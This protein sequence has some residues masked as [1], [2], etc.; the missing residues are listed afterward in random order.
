MTAEIFIIGADGATGGMLENVLE[1]V[2]YK[3]QAFS[4]FPEAMESL[5]PSGTHLVFIDTAS[6]GLDLK[7]EIEAIQRV[8]PNI[9]IILIADYQDPLIEDDARKHH[10]GT[11][12]YRPFS[13]PEVILKVFGALEGAS[14][15]GADGLPVHPEPSDEHLHKQKHNLNQKQ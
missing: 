3:V 9:E 14:S 15:V 10:V 1:A 13:P 11:W 2:G 7:D 8:I 4:G 12:L 6:A 5:S